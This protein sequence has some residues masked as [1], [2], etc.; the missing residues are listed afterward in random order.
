MSSVSSNLLPFIVDLI[1]GNKK[2]PGG[3]KSGEYGGCFNFG[4]SYF[5]KNCFIDTA[6][7]NARGTSFLFP[8]TGVLLDEFFEP[9]KTVHH[10]LQL[11]LAWND[12]HPQI[13]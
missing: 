11:S 13:E 1:S 7:W 4:I 5:A 6:V 9:N 2:K 3:D 8:E 10:P 12:H